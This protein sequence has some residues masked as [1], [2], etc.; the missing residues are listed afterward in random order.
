MTEPGPESG[1]RSGPDSEESFA[2]PGTELDLFRHANNWKRYF[3]A[4][5]RP[6]IRGRVL[7]VGAGLGANTERAY[8]LGEQWVCLEPDSGMAEGLRR[9]LETGKLQPDR[10]MVVEGTMDAVAAEAQFDTILYI[11]VLEHIEG[12]AAELVTA[13]ARLKP[14]GHLLVLSPAHPWLYSPFDEEIGHFRRYTKKSLAAL[15]PG[16][17]TLVRLRY[18][19][20]AGILA[21]AANRFL[22]KK[23]VVARRDIEVWDRLLVPMS[24]LIDPLTLYTLGKSVLAVWRKARQNAEHR[25][26]V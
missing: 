26:T 20:A 18:L 15:Q 5:M 23:A 14:G 19:D 16:G 22:L 3:L 21:S 10:C 4:Q 11:D 13:V 17:T 8:S 25:P 9:M 12:D 7:E 24:R 2:Y 6:F 1:R